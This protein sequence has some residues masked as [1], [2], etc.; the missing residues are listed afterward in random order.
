MFIRFINANS[1]GSCQLSAERTDSIATKR[2][3]GDSEERP[4]STTDG[5]IPG[6][7]RDAVD[8]TALKLAL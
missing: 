5:N 3:F 4:Q 2:L 8:L 6:D 1:C 7:S